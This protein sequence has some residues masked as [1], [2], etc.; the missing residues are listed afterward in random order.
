M[1]SP[2]CATHSRV[3]ALLVALETPVVSVALT[4]QAYWVPGER[5]PIC[6]PPVVQLVPVQAEPAAKFCVVELVG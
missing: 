3:R 5:T 1:R 6:P 4:V 2:V